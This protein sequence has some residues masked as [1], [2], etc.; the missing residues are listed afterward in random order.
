MS[1]AYTNYNQTVFLNQTKLKGVSAVDGSFQIITKPINILGQGF[2]NQV[3]A[4]VPEANF[5]ITRDLV[6]VDTFQKYT[7]INQPIEG[8]I[9]YGNR[10]FGFEKAFLTSYSYSVEY[11]QTPV[12]TLGLTVYGDMGSGDASVVVSSALNASGN[13]QDQQNKIPRPSDITLSCYGSQTNRVKSFSFDVD[14]PKHA[15][16]ALGYQNPVQ[17]STIYPITV[18]TSF[19]LEIDDYQSRRISD[20]LT[21]LSGFDSFSIDVKGIVYDPIPLTA[22][23]E[24]L[25]LPN[26]TKLNFL[27]NNTYSI[28]QLWNFNSSNTKL[29]SQELSSSAE[30]VMQVKLNY[31]TYLNAPTR[32]RFETV[33]GPTTGPIIS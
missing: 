5:S 25:T 24:Q 21:S 9:F 17:V 2:I 19:T 32:A 7:G 22:N 31:L 29:I 28:S 27:G 11:G 3:V 16:Y 15:I 30:D 20:Y 1:N 13:I 8:S 23:N 10:V 18:N 6:F 4:D 26:G 33:T 14:I 12:S